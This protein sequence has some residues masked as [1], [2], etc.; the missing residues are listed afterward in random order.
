MELHEALR[1][2]LSERS[3]GT[4]EEIRLCLAGLGLDVT[5]STVSRT[6]KRLGAIRAASEGGRP[7]YRLPAREALDSRIEGDASLKG[8]LLNIVTNGSLIVLHTAPGSASLIAR[9]LDQKRPAGILGTIAGDDTIFVAPASV[10]GVPHAMA[11]IR[12]LFS[13][14]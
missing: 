5:Q 7:R 11:A 12:S 6:L 1:R 14:A 10:E 4:Q 8:M 2:V 13:S 3:P 9:V